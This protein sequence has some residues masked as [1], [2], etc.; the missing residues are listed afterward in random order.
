M[1]AWPF[2]CTKL[3]YR[4]TD[5]EHC[6]I[7]ISSLSPVFALLIRK[8]SWIK[9]ERSYQIHAV[10]LCKIEGRYTEGRHTE[11]PAKTFMACKLYVCSKSKHLQGNVNTRHLRL[12]NTKPNHG[13]IPPIVWLPSVYL[14]LH[15]ITACDEISHTF[16]TCIGSCDS[17][18]WQRAWMRLATSV[19]TWLFKVSTQVQ[20]RRFYHIRDISV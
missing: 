3:S 17:W 1:R 10:I 4:V 6:Q 15:Y 2:D 9:L 12:I 16:Y 7:S 20:A 11:G 5:L 13:W 14:M 19:A 8:Y 18:K